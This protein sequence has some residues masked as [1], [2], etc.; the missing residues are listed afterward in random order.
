MSTSRG[1]NEIASVHFTRAR[2][3]PFGHWWR[4][5]IDRL[6]AGKSVYRV[7]ELVADRIGDVDGPWMWRHSAGVRDDELSENVGI[8]GFHRGSLVGR[9]E[10]GEHRVAG[11]DLGQIA[12]D[13]H[14]LITLRATSEVP[15]HR[16]NRFPSRR[17]HGRLPRHWSTRPSTSR[18]S[19]TGRRASAS[20][21]S[22]S[23]CTRAVSATKSTSVRRSRS[24]SELTSR[25]PSSCRPTKCGSA[26]AEVGRRDLYHRDILGA[27]PPRQRLF[28]VRARR[29]RIGS[30]Q[31]GRGGSRS[32]NHMVRPGARGTPW[33]RSF[34]FHAMTE[35]CGSGEE[36]HSHLIRM[37]RWLAILRRCCPPVSPS[38]R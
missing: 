3:D 22:R 26:Q 9:G 2:R 4:I 37:A 34:A 32:G 30:G 7:F 35:R 23:I 1:V 28:H 33:I 20:S 15:P 12:F 29:A 17:A 25:K 13:D 8:L 24:R 10:G 14:G 16:V 18:L 5:S 19:S 38:S 11:L 21:R 31:P 36:S 27:S 6:L